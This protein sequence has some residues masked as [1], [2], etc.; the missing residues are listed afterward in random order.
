MRSTRAELPPDP[1][2]W[3]PP[4]LHWR[5]RLIK[6]SLLLSQK[7]FCLCG[8]SVERRGDYQALV[9]C[10]L[11]QLQKAERQPLL[12]LHSTF[13]LLCSASF[14]QNAMEGHLQRKMVSTLCEYPESGPCCTSL[15]VGC[16][17]ILTVLRILAPRAILMLLDHGRHGDSQFWTSYLTIRRWS[18]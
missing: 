17:Q 15:H 16:S 14:C 7:Q 8:Q 4:T 18:R 10:L 9:K 12:S 1:V 3:K 13:S 6:T 2:N 5:W 11:P